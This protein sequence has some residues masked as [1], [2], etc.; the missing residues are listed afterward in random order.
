V[1]PL[2]EQQA[3][4]QQFAEQLEGPVKIDLFTQR[5]T[6][7]FVPGREECP[8]CPH[9]EQLLEEIAHL[10]DKI[11][12]RVYERGSDRALEERYGIDKV[13]AF[14]VRGVI[15]RPLVFFGLPAAELFPLLI[16]SILMASL[17][18]PTL[19]PT[20]RRRLKRLKRTVRVQVFALPNAPHCGEQ[21]SLALAL[22]L[23]DQHIRA[24]IVEISEF[25]AL[26][27]RYEI[28][29]VPMTIIDDKVALPGVTPVDDLVTEIV[30]ATEQRTITARSALITGTAAE[31]STPLPPPPTQQPEGGRVLPSG[32]IIPG[33]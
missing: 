18:A 5:P 3:L 24:E 30:R 22:A 31:T 26:A 15:N 1:I 23:G 33:R 27:N 6:S 9:A 28:R 19:P 10:S 21:A 17:P 32:L 16:E 8:F 25:P 12:L 11:T 13:P 2:R 7:V 14:V 29:A 4:R 20:V